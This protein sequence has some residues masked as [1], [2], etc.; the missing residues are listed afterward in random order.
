METSPRAP[1]RAALAAGIL[2]ALPVLGFGLLLARPSLDG[3]WAHQPSHLWIVLGAGLLNAALAYA[4]GVAAERRSDL[5][6]ALVA[7]AFLACAGFLGLHALATPGVLLDGANA[8]FVVA[9]PVG[10]ALAGALVAASSLVPDAGPPAWAVR[11]LPAL[12]WG[13]VGLVA[14][15]AAWSLA[16]LPPLDD[17]VSLRGSPAPV[18]MAGAALALYGIALVRYAALLRRRPSSLVLGLLIGLALL[19]EATLATAV[20]T[21]WH[22]SWW[23]WHVLILAASAIVAVAA[24]VQWHEE[25]FGDLYLRSTAEGERDLSV[26]FADLQ[27]FTRFAEGADPRE[28]SRMLNS[29]LGAAIPVI[30]RRHGGEIDRIMGDAIMATFNRAGDRPDHAGDAVRAA[31]ALQEEAGRV[32]A[33]HPGWPRFRAGVNTGPAIVCV[34]G[35]VGGRTW[36]VVGDTVNVASR[37]EGLA[38]PGG[39]ALGAETAA[40]VPGAR[41][42]SLGTVALKGRVGEVEALLLVGLEPAAPAAL[43]ATSA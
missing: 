8:G 2:L 14:V 29:Y 43:P 21:S 40:R 28:V 20:T 30:V 16:E 35:A 31:V 12:R 4:V 11:W 19:A 7:L 25:R 27:G 33:E 41:T 6:V 13:I 42:E 10:L 3:S 37:L 39:V 38:P 22:A 32:A 18:A 1:S 24:H 36:S 23:G 34:L 9:T 17:E 15:W 5:R 26:L